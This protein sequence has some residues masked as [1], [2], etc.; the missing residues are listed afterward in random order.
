[1]RTLKHTQLWRGKTCSSCVA[2]EASAAH[3][4]RSLSCIDLKGLE[5]RLQA[6]KKLNSANSDEAPPQCRNRERAASQRAR[7]ECSKN[8]K[9]G[10]ATFV[11]CEGEEVQSGKG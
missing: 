5:T 8:C 4:W 9:S 7:H 2:A 6:A 10:T 1:M 11:T 3:A